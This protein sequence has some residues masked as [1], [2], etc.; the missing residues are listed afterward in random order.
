MVLKNFFFRERLQFFWPKSKNDEKS[1]KI[2]PEFRLWA[3]KM[4][5]WQ[6][7]TIFSVVL[8]AF[9][10]LRGTNWVKNDCVENFSNLLSFW[11]FHRR[12]LDLSESLLSGL[13]TV[14]SMC[15][16]EHF[17]NY[18]YSQVF[19]YFFINF[20]LIEKSLGH[21]SV[22]FLFFCQPHFSRVVKD[23]F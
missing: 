10:V 18:L 21:L 8:I 4:R 6:T 14:I 9:Y 13:L 5:F 2:S 1:K 16:N 23:D 15:P 22:N 3:K 19:L 12:D 7:K 20:G 17:E 11:E